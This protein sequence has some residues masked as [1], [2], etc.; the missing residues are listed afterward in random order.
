[1]DKDDARKNEQK[2]IL[3]LIISRYN[4]AERKTGSGTATANRTNSPVLIRIA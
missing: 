4:Y 3:C 2:M 1:M